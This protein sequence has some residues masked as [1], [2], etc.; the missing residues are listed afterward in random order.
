MTQNK[1]AWGSE[2]EWFHAIDFG[3]AVTP[4]RG[5]GA[6]PNW[7]L[8]GT[9][10]YLEGIEVQGARCLDIGTMD[11]LVAM[12]LAKRGSSSVVATDLYDRPT[13]LPRGPRKIGTAGSDHIPPKHASR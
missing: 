10:H 1:E 5:P 7:S 4:G 6:P 2:Y 12:M 8:F 13:I 9:F 11:G 3:D